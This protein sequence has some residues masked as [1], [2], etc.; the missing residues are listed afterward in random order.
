MY[1]NRP[2]QTIMFC[3]RGHSIHEGKSHMGENG[4]RLQGV[5]GT[6]LGL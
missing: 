6:D 1:T 2:E 5:L 3:N 4:G